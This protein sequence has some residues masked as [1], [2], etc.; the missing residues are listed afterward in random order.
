MK[1][2]SEC[3]FLVEL[4]NIHYSES[5]SYISFLGILLWVILNDRFNGVFI[6]MYKC[7][8]IYSISGMRILFFLSQA[9]KLAP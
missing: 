8:S 3:D 9:G 4:P 7:M 2:T 1:V 6:Y 5:N